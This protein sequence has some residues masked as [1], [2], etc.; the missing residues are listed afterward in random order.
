MMLL[1]LHDTNVPD[2]EPEPHLRSELSVAVSLQL[3]SRRALSSSGG[4]L[5]DGEKQIAGSRSSEPW[6][7][8]R[9]VFGTHQVVTEQNG[10]RG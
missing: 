5:H 10:P 8:V 6:Y 7:L 1:D 2:T 3:E 9:A 4:L